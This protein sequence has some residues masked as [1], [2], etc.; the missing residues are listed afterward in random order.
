MKTNHWASKWLWLSIALSAV[1]WAGHVH[2]A[3]FASTQSGSWGNA[4][5][6]GGAGIP[7]AGD[8]VTISLGTT[9]QLDTTRFTGDLTVNGTLDMFNN[10]LEFQGTTFTNNGA[11][12]NTTGGQLEFKGVAGAASTTQ[13]IAGA[14]TWNSGAQAGVNVLNST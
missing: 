3:N 5:T 13:T 11:V 12:A 7:G 14:G 4:A 8:N 6:W 9:V 1:A 2:A 10:Y